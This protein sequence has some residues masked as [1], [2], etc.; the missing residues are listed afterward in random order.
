MIQH[1][2]NLDTLLRQAAQLGMRRPTPAQA[3][4][5]RRVM[6]D[7]NEG[8]YVPS[9]HLLRIISVPPRLR[10]DLLLVYRE[11]LRL[12]RQQ[13]LTEEQIL[14]ILLLCKVS[15]TVPWEGEVRYL[16]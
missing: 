2:S 12:C 7:L 16:S 14:Y 5:L 10:G 3:R 8:L 6:D 4:R 11:F 13:F 9:P 15:V 1:I